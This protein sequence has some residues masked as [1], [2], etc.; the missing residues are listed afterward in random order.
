M[1]VADDGVIECRARH[2]CDNLY[3]VVLRVTA[4]KAPKW[5]FTGRGGLIGRHGTTVVWRLRSDGHSRSWKQTRARREDVCGPCGLLKTHSERGTYPLPDDTCTRL[6]WTERKEFLRETSCETRFERGPRNGVYN[7][8]NQ[9]FHIPKRNTNPTVAAY[10]CTRQSRI[11]FLHAR[12]L[13]TCE[14][15]IDSIQQRPIRRK[16]DPRVPPKRMNRDRYCAVRCA[17][18]RP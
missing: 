1:L 18:S 5:P 11:K 7:Y 16:S 15:K 10:P 9:V 4:K 14:S 17:C 2:A 8:K 13:I 6:T 12:S 3:E